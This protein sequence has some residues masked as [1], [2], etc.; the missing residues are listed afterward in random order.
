MVLDLLDVESPFRAG[1]ESVM[2]GA[3]A[4]GRTGK[5]FRTG[6]IGAIAKVG[7]CSPANHVFGFTTQVN[8]V[9]NYEVVLPVYDFLVGFV[10]RL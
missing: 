9:R 4:E 2:R 7:G 6:G 1:N 3:G 10:G 8:I 5:G